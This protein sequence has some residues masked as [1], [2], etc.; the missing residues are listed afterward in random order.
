MA[1]SLSNDKAIDDVLDPSM[2]RHVS[3]KASNVQQINLD[4]ARAT[5]AEHNMSLRQGLKLYP[6]AIGWS[7]LL[8]A[9]IIMEGFDIVLISNLFAVPAFKK[10]F[11]VKLPNG[12]YELTSSWQ[13][14]LTNGAVVGELLG[15][16]IN[17]WIADRFGYKK[18]MI[19]ALLAVNFLIF[20]LF[21]AESV[22]QLLAGLVLIGIPWGI[23]QTLTTTYAAEVC[24]VAL[25]AYLTTYVN[26]CWVI[27]QFLAS[28]VLKG[29][30]TRED[31]WAYRIPYAL[32]WM[33]PIPLIV[34]ITFAPGT[35]DHH[36]SVFKD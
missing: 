11:G 17:G 29:V 16:T 25:R 23:F 33:W 6:K 13:S 1:T 10:Q 9:A 26:L 24:P 30:S 20:I 18:T 2:V 3:T 19:G 7:V 15:L 22:E 31:E 14:G 8:S 4:A 28:A 32:Q 35:Y 36:E 34:G 12:N 27:G 21:F 5:E